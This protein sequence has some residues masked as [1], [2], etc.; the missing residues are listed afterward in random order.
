[1]SAHPGR[2][3]RERLLTTRTGS[4]AAGRAQTQRLQRGQGPVVV[5][6]VHDQRSR[7]VLGERGR[8]PLQGAG[9]VEV[10]EGDGP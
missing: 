5:G 7:G 8:Q 4:A 9:P 10:K 1:M 3:S 6:A 2:A